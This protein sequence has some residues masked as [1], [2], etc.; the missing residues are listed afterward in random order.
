M[1]NGAWCETSSGLR[2]DLPYVHRDQI[3]IRDIGH[4]L[5]LQCRFNGHCRKF[6]SVA[7]HSV[8][9]ARLLQHGGQ[10]WRVQLLGLIHDASEASLG[11]MV[12]PLK[13]LLPDFRAIETWVQREVEIVLAG[14]EATPDDHRLVKA[15]DDAL[16]ATEARSLIPSEGS[17]WYLPQPAVAGL[18]LDAW[19]PQT[20]KRRFLGTYFRLATVLGLHIED[21]STRKE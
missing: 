15:A 10:S 13:G 1:N 19:D 21:Q 18:L 8:L 5:S 12:R 9:V 20:A 17:N 16:L 7:Q 6:Y 11:D 2:V 4:A 14:S 3:N